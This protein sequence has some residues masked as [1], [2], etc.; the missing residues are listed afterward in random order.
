MQK[1]LHVVLCCSPASQE[2]DRL[3]SAYPGLIVRSTVN[4]YDDWPAKAL[5]K[6][7]LKQLSTCHLAREHI[8]P[9]VFTGACCIPATIEFHLFGTVGFAADSSY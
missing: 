9:K 4:V 5:F 1:N 6:V 7:A 2:L 8:L 3:C